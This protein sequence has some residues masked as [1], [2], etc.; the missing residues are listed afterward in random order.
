MQSSGS[1]LEEKILSSHCF[2]STQ[3]KRIEYFKRSVTDIT[4]TTEEEYK[5]QLTW[6]CRPE[7]RCLKTRNGPE[8][9]VVSEMIKQLPLEKIDII[10]RCFQERYMG[11]MEAPSSWKV[12]K[13]A[14]LRKPD[15]EP[16]KE[17]RSYRA[18]A[19]TSVMSKW[20]ASCVI[21]RLEKENEPESWKKWHLG[22]I[23]GVNCQIL[24]VMITNL[25]QKHWE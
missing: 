25:L 15:A 6:C 5:L 21:L 3:E 13:L 14:F 20:Y 18:I 11:K 4:R 12:V 23:E 8:D 2:T 17:I 10:T 19:L 24:Q 1:N 9:A 7:Q 22:G 16:K